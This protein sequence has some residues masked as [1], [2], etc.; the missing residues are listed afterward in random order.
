MPYRDIDTGEI[1]DEVGPN[2]TVVEG[3][4]SGSL[5]D[6]LVSGAND[7]ADWFG[8]MYDVGKSLYTGELP[9]QEDEESSWLGSLAASTAARI[10]GRIASTMGK[11]VDYFAENPMPFG[12]GLFTDDYIADLLPTRAREDANYAADFLQEAG[13]RTEEA[14]KRKFPASGAKEW[15]SDII[16][17]AGEAVASA[18]AGGPAG[19]GAYFVGSPFLETYN[20][21]EDT[22]GADTAELRA[23]PAGALGGLLTRYLPSGGSLIPRALKSA[24]VMGLFG[25]PESALDTAYDTIDGADLTQQEVAQRMI[26][27]SA[28]NAATGL[29]MEIGGASARGAKAAYQEISTRAQLSK[30]KTGIKRIGELDD[31]TKSTNPE[32]PEAVKQESQPRDVPAPE[33]VTGDIMA[34]EET[35]LPGEVQNI[36]KAGEVELS[37]AQTRKIR[38]AAGLPAHKERQ[39]AF[40]RPLRDTLYDQTVGKERQAR[41][42]RQLK[43][44]EGFVE[45]KNE[46]FPKMEFSQTTEKGVVPESA[47]PIRARQEAVRQD[48]VLPPNAK[49]RIAATFEPMTK[50]IEENVINNDTVTAIEKMVAEKETSKPRKSRAA[51]KARNA[52]MDKQLALGKESDLWLEGG[53]GTR[54]A[55]SFPATIAEKHPDSKA[56]HNHYYREMEVGSRVKAQSL[57]ALAPYYGL[58][59]ADR[60]IAYGM[61]AEA[62]LNP[63]FDPS[64]ENYMASDATRAQAEGAMAIHNYMD[65]FARPLMFQSMRARGDLLPADKKAAWNQGVDILEKA[66]YRKNYTP[67]SRFGSYR[68]N[69]KDPV[70]GENP[71]FF[72]DGFTDWGA[73]RAAK[74]HKAE[75]EAQGYEVRE[76]ERVSNLR[77]DVD[78]YGLS[79][80]MKELFETAYNLNPQTKAALSEIAK[81]YGLS[82]IRGH[83]VGAKDVP[84]FEMNGDKVLAHYV[85]N[86]A[87]FV[88]YNTARPYQ[89]VYLD[90]L[91]KTTSNTYN[92]WKEFDDY[93]HKPQTDHPVTKT[94]KML[95]VVSHLPKPITSALNFTQ[96]IT[97]SYALASK[98]TKNPAAVIARN[99]IRAPI[100]LRDPKNFKGTPELKAY[101]ERLR[102][103]GAF[104]D[105]NVKEMLGTARLSDV[106]QRVDKAAN[107]LLVL[108]SITER[109]N[110]VHGALT[111]WDI[112]PKDV[113]ANP[114]QMREF[115]RDFI[116][117]TEGDYTKLNRPKFARSD[118][119]SMA[120]L[121]KA[122]PGMMFKML[123]NE[124][125]S[126]KSPVVR[127]A[128]GTFLAMGGLTATVPFFNEA[129]KSVKA[130]FGINV[131][132]WLRENL[133][134]KHVWGEGE[135]RDLTG[136]PTFA[137]IVLYGPPVMGG[138]V[139]GPMLS[140]FQVSSGPDR[141]AGWLETLARTAAG[142]GFS[143][144]SD[145]VLGTF[146]SLKNTEGFS[147][148]YRTAKA[149]Q[150]ALPN[151][152]TGPSRV[153]ESFMTPDGSIATSGGNTLLEDPS[154]L[155]KFY[156]MLGGN[157]LQLQKQ[158]DLVGSK[159]EFSEDKASANQGLGK[160]MY[161][162]L[163]RGDRGL[164]K[165]LRERYV[166]QGGANPDAALKYQ[167]N[168]AKYPEQMRLRSLPRSA[169][170]EY[171]RKYGIE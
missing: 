86:L 32:L 161:R 119:G 164:Y 131:K 130:L 115:A 34:R 156:M 49:E 87:N 109:A 167:R 56:L 128:V 102:E 146:E 53:L 98:Y 112:A 81:T 83:L 111:A 149:I 151:F 21:Y 160:A 17:G 95:A 30:I 45:N 37:D 79:P 20:K 28:E 39:P 1:I 16:P 100:Y 55:I 2:D 66:T 64:V 123:K 145:K 138:L 77:P 101:M 135:L 89:E 15:I 117:T 143:T 122:M 113:R 74:K 11:A 155:T 40:P 62:R 41:Y 78:P 106:G 52:E 13:N 94:A 38:Q 157:P 67:F 148:G 36:L 97:F 44:S 22:A 3:G 61:T 104:Q 24:G 68:L 71:V 50:P 26:D 126:P 125:F 170:G 162:A 141:D 147:P 91:A 159:I 88:G 57:E 96:P 116:N 14:V 99:Y 63:K 6:M 47:E 75:L 33:K 132:D 169:R 166:K 25:I 9:E 19:L 152:V 80:E 59:Q 18:V 150:Q 82:G 12:G 124:G 134:D 84:G 120:F 110:R 118:L 142:A 158:R 73:K 133:G 127:R 121:F 48:P 4:G 93:I 129:E 60:N 72:H 85:D 43:T 139:T 154:L 5:A 65:H 69:A 27:R 10:P 54:R 90:K 105:T 51:K 31:L 171:K 137:D 103:E 8:G 29:A 42:E 136:D 107:A 58:S 46:I 108:H 70:T 153:A 168:W 23:I 92:Y 144:A 7:V 35:S 76:P 114:E 165:E 163:E 140:L